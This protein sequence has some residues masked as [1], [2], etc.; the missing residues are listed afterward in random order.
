MRPRWNKIISDLLGHKVRSLL[1]IA[2]IAV[3]LFA[4]GMITTS[5]VILSEDIRS[6]YTAVNP[7]NIQVRTSFFDDEFVSHI[8]SMEGI[9]GAQGVWNTSL[10]IRSAEGE[11]KPLNI[12]AQ[13]F[14][15][16]ADSAIGAPSLL[17]GAWPPEDKQIVLDTNRL[18][19]IGAQPGDEV[20]IR[21]PSGIIRS[22]PVVGIVRDQTLGADDSTGGYFLAD[23]Q[24]YVTEATLPWLEQP[25]AFNTL[26][27]TVENEPERRDGLRSLANQVV[28]KF[29]Q[30]G[31][32]VRSTLVRL[33][34]EHPNLPYVDAI[35]AVIYALGFLVVF[36]SGFLITNTFSAL[37]NQQ[38][39]QIGVMKTFGASRRQ[40]ILMF[41]VLILVFSL[42]ALAI[43][44]PLSH[45]AAYALLRYLAGKINFELSSFRAVPA[46]AIFQLIIALLVPQ[47]AGILPIL[48]GTRIS[49]REALSGS[50]SSP[51]ESKGFIYRML[52][53]FRR[54]SRPLRISLRNTF[55][56]RGRLVLTLITLTL[57]G[58]T[59]IATFNVR[60]SLDNYVDRLGRYFLADVNVTMNQLYRVD[61]VKRD[62][63]QVPG[64]ADVEGWSSASG[65]LVLEDGKEGE[66]VQILAPPAGSQLIDPMLLEGR[67]LLPEDENALVL[68]EQFLSQLPRPAARRYP[69]GERSAI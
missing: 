44:I 24:G 1:V 46:S 26:Y 23:L 2:S 37:L 4:I 64:I 17:E 45:Q 7:A 34:F 13:D 22:L 5:Y 25:E 42:I 68:S 49:V 18:S 15:G 16:G 3:G 35:A 21:L 9:S 50:S 62:L 63:Q 48:Q 56:R 60:N 14:G 47:L 67:W 11:W 29:N 43:S 10:Q 41:M 66:S 36:L 38:V 65:N 54:L 52:A 30:N 6:G 19:E 27:A 33:S 39:Q 8:R 57:G 53:R 40:I 59:F 51:A 69:A 28:E 55:R 12:K 20:E 31:Y 58:A 61:K 32:P